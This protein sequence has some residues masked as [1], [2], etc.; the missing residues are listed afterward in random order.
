MPANDN[1]YDIQSKTVGM[2][3]PLLRIEDNYS[4]I[5]LKGI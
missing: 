2:I 1:L 4:I 3:F 5:M